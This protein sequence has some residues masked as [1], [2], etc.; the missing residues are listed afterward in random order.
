MAE[1]VIRYGFIGV[2]NMASAIIRA[3]TSPQRN[4]VVPFRDLFLY[5]PLTEKTDRFSKEGAHACSGIPE[6]VASSDLIVLAVKPQQYAQVLADI[7][8]SGISLSGKTFVSLAAGVDTD[9]V[10]AGLGC[11]AAVVRTM[12]NTPLLVGAGVTALCRN[13]A[14][15]DAAFA[16]VSGMFSAAGAV[17]VL[18]ESEMNAIIAVTSSAVAYYYEFMR[19][20]LRGARQIGLEEEQL[21][22]AVAHT[23]IGAAK[24][25]LEN[26][27][28]SL[29]KLI[30]MVT[31][32]KGTT[33]QALLAFRERDLDGTVAAG[34]IACTRRAEELGAALRASLEEAGTQNHE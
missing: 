30:D 26:P 23:A 32:Y 20:V 3:I 29:D 15:T 1:T 4:P 14:V 6:V 16:T 7:R 22:D 21:R 31:S 33:E 24:M 27:Q 18:P 19:A 25:V 13:D 5:D 11:K 12:P 10:S 9:A 8:Q 28:L 17:L 34:M 2:G